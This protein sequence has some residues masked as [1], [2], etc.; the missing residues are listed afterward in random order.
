M[1]SVLKKV[2][3]EEFAGNFDK[4]KVSPDIVCFLSAQELHQLGLSRKEEMVKL[5]MECIKY[6]ANRLP[7]RSNKSGTPEFVIPKCILQNLIDDGFL[8][9]DIAKLLS[10]SESTVY[11]RMRK[12]DI[13]KVDFSNMNDDEIGIH[14]GKVI[15]EFPFCGENILKQI[16]KLQG[17]HVQRWRLRDIIHS[18]DEKGEE[19]MKNG[20][21]LVDRGWQQQYYD[22]LKKLHKQNSYMYMRLLLK[23]TP[24]PHPTNVTLTVI[25][26]IVS[27][28]F[29]LYLQHHLFP[30]EKDQ[31]N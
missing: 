2:G 6:G 8:I 5:R 10:V 31:M 17:V 11:R 15:K 9:S 26:H 29:I 16:L 28:I 25:I 27:R 3:L 19:D 22:Q 14:V 20:R 24:S 23:K 30:L 1:F 7:R 13:A 21:L 12:Y 4:Q 18:I